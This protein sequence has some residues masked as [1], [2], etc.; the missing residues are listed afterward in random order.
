M[1]MMVIIIIIII[2]IVVVRFSSQYTTVLD[3]AFQ[4]C[5]LVSEFVYL[6]S[7]SD[8]FKDNS[9]TSETI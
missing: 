1:M 7:D 4:A 6:L 9:K 3:R 8:Y 2:I 5:L